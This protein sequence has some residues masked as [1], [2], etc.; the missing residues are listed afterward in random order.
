MPE[1]YPLSLR[2]VLR[3]SK[4][5]SQPPAFGMA[6]P[7]RGFGYVQ[8]VGTDTPVFWSVAFRFT[9]DEALVFQLW[10]AKMINRGIDAFTL[11]I[12]TEFGLITHTCRFLPDSLLTTDEQGETWGYT[13]TIMARAQIIPDD[14]G[15]AAALIVGL[16][17][18]RAWASLLDE[19]VNEV[20]PLSLV[21]G[22]L[23]GDFMVFNDGDEEFLID[24]GGGDYLIFI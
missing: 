6:D 22:G 20:M 19:T 3:A 8:A 1:A 10:F 2:T 7:R 9:R 4:S 16:P 15:D 12:R 23:D 14:Y 18:W 5:R 13:A 17:N 24:V 21:G 11:P